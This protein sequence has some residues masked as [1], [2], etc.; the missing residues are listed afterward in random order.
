MLHFIIKVENNKKILIALLNDP[1]AKEIM[2][3]NV[4]VL[5]PKIESDPLRKPISSPNHTM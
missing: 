2:D 3:N 1:N 4:P 5:I